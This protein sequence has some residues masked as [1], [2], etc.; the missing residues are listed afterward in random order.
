VVTAA[1]NIDRNH[2]ARYAAAGLSDFY[3]RNF[4]QY[5]QLLWGTN[6]GRSYYDSLQVS[7]RRQS[8]PLKFVTNYTWSKTLDLASSQ[9]DAPTPR[10]IDSFNLRLSGARSDQDRSHV[11]NGS[12]IYT[13]PVGKGH[14]VG[15]HWPGWLD[16]VLG[17]WDA[18]A[19]GLWESGAVFSVLSGRRTGGD[20]AAS[21]SYANYTGDRNIGRVDRRSDGIFWFS[22]EEIQRFSF[23]AAG[24]I[25]SSGHNAFRGPRHFDVDLSLLKRFSLTDR[26]SL[27]FRAEFFNLFNNTNFRNPSAVLNNP[28]SFGRISATASVG[29]AIP[30]GGTAG[31]PRIAQLVL[32]YEF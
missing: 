8:G 3:L 15:N 18:G 16:A 30:V 20:V 11:F 24:E 21:Q 29:S 26:Q 27:A 6:D 25:G 13:L 32:R 28:A 23:P 10:P 19:L 9:G 7:L 17:G 12:F 14:P 1:D 5:D 4:P 31:G 2:N 22:P